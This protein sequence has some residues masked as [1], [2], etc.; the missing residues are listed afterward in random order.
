MKF[1]LVLLLLTNQRFRVMIQRIIINLPNGL[2][3][4][5][6]KEIL[7]HSFDYRKITTQSIRL[8][9]ENIIKAGRRKRY[10]TDI[11]PCNFSHN[12]KLKNRLKEFRFD[13]VITIH[14]IF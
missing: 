7:T 2:F 12:L 3:L 8:E 10:S 14:Q 4:N 9:L 5:N 13:N 6:H 1:S 11:A